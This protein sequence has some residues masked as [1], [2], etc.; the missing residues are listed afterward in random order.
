LG[1]VPS[2][3]RSQTATNATHADTAASAG[4][5]TSAGDAKALGGKPASAFAA[6]NVIRSAT[7]LGD[8]SVVT[9]LSDGVAQGNIGPHTPDS[10]SYCIDGLNPPPTAAIATVGFG[11]SSQSTIFTDVTPPGGLGCN[12]YVSI[13]GVG[14][15]SV[16]APF[17]I[18]LH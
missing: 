14:G 15:A 18:L 7:V 16:D 12:V 17:T 1:T 10:G 4:S 8:G 9:A 5:A 2:A 3:V 13:Y 6:S 11:A